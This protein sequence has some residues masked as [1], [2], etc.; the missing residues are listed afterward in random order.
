MTGSAR[1]RI[2]ELEALSHKAEAGD[3]G[4][5]K[6]LRQALRESAPEVITRCSDSARV[7]RRFLAKTASGENPLVE[8]AIVERAGML[9]AET[10]SVPPTF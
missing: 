10:D 1:A 7:Y 4:A 6:E 8:E 5:K 3:K 2:R 9:A